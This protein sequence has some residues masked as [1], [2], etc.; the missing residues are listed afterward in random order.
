MGTLGLMCWRPVP[1]EKSSLGEDPKGE[2]AGCAVQQEAGIR[3]LMWCCFTKGRSK[4]CARVRG[5]LTARERGPSFPCWPPAWPVAVPCGSAS[6]ATSLLLPAGQ[7]GCGVQLT[8]RQRGGHRRRS[9]SGE[10]EG[11]G[12]ATVVPFVFVLDFH[13]CI[14]CNHVL[15][16]LQPRLR[17]ISCKCLYLV[18]LR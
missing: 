7:P 11:W 18:Y 5:P 2:E 6:Q 15:G 17:S 12:G 1:R 3:G 8:D 10:R 4:L 13:D 16:V 14:H 9:R